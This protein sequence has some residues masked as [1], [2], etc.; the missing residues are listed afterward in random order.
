MLPSW[1]R[2]A[3][4]YNGFDDRCR[5]SR[6]SNEPSVTEGL[7][8]AGR[9]SSKTAVITG[10]SRG[11]G[12]GIARVFAAEGARVL[13]VG[14]DPRAASAVVEEIRRAGGEADFCR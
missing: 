2:S 10:S 3:G 8:M 13:I 1:A 9:L 11:L 6:F 12:K 4:Q 14:R 7:D 5:L